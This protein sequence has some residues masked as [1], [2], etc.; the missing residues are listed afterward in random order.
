M[1]TTRVPQKMWMLLPHLT[2]IKI[3]YQQ[4]ILV[5]YAATPIRE[6]PLFPLF[7]KLVKWTLTAS[8]LTVVFCNSSFQNSWLTKCSGSPISIVT[9]RQLTHIK[10]DDHITAA[11]T[12]VTET[13][14]G[15]ACDTV[16][17]LMEWHTGGHDWGLSSIT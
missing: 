13:P 17:L 11:K 3:Q 15:V 4:K 7:G 10:V 5:L 1:M 6:R 8:H 14:L 9:W 2:R 12:S 16:T